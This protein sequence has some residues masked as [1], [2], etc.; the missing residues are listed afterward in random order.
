M[1]GRKEGSLGGIWASKGMPTLGR[2][3]RAWT[4]VGAKDTH[5]S[6]F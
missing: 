2:R 1:R 4:T 3:L 5:Y 6:P